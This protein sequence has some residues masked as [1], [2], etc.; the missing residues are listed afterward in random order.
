MKT[1]T[2]STTWSPAALPPRRDLALRP[3]ADVKFAAVHPQRM[4]LIALVKRAERIA[5][6]LPHAAVECVDF[7]LGISGEEPA[8]V[9]GQRVRGAAEFA[10]LA[11]GAVAFVHV[12][13]S[14]GVADVK[15]RDIQL[16]P[17]RGER[18]QPMMLARLSYVFPIVF[19]AKTIDAAKTHLRR[20]PAVAGRS[21]RVQVA[22]VHA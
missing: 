1:W 8:V 3:T 19:T 18:I 16:A 9:Y 7:A 4:N 21:R 10:A 15:C 2:C 14:G 20:L 17:I 6:V 11:P 5:Q 13:V 22:I 12:D